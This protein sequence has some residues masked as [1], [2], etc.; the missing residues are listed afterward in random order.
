L[1]IQQDRLQ[2]HPMEGQ[3]LTCKTVSKCL[4]LAIPVPPRMII[5]G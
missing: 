5:A 4:V 1:V 2:I 3:D